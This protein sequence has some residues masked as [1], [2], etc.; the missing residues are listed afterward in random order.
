MLVPVCF[1]ENNRIQYL[2]YG[3]MIFLHMVQDS[4]KHHLPVLSSAVIFRR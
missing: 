1:S 3:S 2:L 4:E